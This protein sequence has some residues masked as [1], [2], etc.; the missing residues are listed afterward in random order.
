[1]FDRNDMYKGREMIQEDDEI[2]E[3]NIGTD[4]SPRIIKLRKGTT[5][6]E[7]EQLLALI[8]EFKDVFSWSYGDLKS[9]LRGFHTTCYSPQG[10]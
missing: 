1:M 3:V 10:G 7:R 6:S 2:I 9:Y 4:A 8:R 5:P